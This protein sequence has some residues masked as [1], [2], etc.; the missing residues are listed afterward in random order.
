MSGLDLQTINKRTSVKLF[1]ILFIGLLFLGIGIVSLEY[2]NKI[3]LL[4]NNSV[5]TQE[6]FNALYLQALLSFILFVTASFII[7]YLASLYFNKYQKEISGPVFELA[8]IANKI[9]NNTYFSV[10]EIPV[11]A[12]EITTIYLALA[13]SINRMHDKNDKLIMSESRLQEILDNSI[14]SITI[15]DLEGVI[16]YSNK[17]FKNFLLR[18]HQHK[19]NNSH[20]IQDL[21]GNENEANTQIAR[22]RQVINTG[23]P[24]KYETKITLEDGIHFFHIVKIPLH[25]EGKVY[26]ICTISNEITELKNQ[27]ELLKR[28]QKMEALGKLTGGIAH[29]YNNMLAVIIGF[30]QLIEYSPKENPKIRK[31]AKEI[32]KAGN[33]G[34]KL[35]SKLLAFSRTQAAEPR[36]TNISDLITAD[37]HMLEK[38]LTARIQLQLELNNE[39]WSVWIDQDDLQDAILNIC[40][41]AMHAIDGNGTIAIKT[42]NV[43]IDQEQANKISVNEGDYVFIQISD[44]GMG[45]NADVVA[46]IFDPFFSTKGESG[47][48]L[49]LSQVYGFVKRSEGAIM[50]DS[51]PGKGSVF[52]IYFPRNYRASSAHAIEDMKQS[53]KLKGTES[54][55][56]VDDEQALLSITEEILGQA[57]YKIVTAISAEKAL[58]ILQNN[59]FN[60]LFSD[61]IMPGMSGYELAREARKK[62]PEMK[63]QLTSGYD[64]NSQ[65]DA[66]HTLLK[67][68]TLYKPY[69]DVKLLKTIR[70]VLDQDIK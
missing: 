10:P 33:R 55:L 30:S 64:H 45:M 51:E 3:T 68:K 47:S 70:N 7:S 34:A 36:N 52:N 54:I 63:I 9:S 43:N 65:G 32:K 46:H 61:V 21:L 60:L 59:T 35:T 31:Y 39:L 23:K 66:E 69:G 42:D 6:A 13:N 53:S 16:T 28:S 20:K 38:T 8:A 50:V 2:Y 19:N 26:A 15:K 25:D 40:I 22:D 12:D 24:V 44:S 62:Y 11:C 14:L 48:G 5:L 1:L 56:I 17:H 18:N 4:S 67:N 57:G 49:G 37:L 27:G 41:N 58:E 29:D